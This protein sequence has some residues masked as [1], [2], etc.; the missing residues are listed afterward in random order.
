MGRTIRLEIVFV[1]FL[2]A[3]GMIIAAV[4]LKYGF[5]TLKRPGS[6]LYP[7]FIGVAIL[8]FSSILALSELKVR[9]TARLMEQGGLKTFIWMIVTFCLWIVAMPWLGYVIVTF[10]AACAFCKIMKLETWWK[11]LAIAAG[12]A[13]FI[14]LLFD[15]WLYIDLPRGILG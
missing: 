7:F 2:M 3:L 13:I 9:K 11:P 8:L 5:G 4:S 14:Y 10:L 12:T 6:G 15:C 1:F